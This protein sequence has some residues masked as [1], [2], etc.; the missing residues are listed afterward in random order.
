MRP[1]ISP[2]RSAEHETH[3]LGDPTK[4]MMVRFHFYPQADGSQHPCQP[5]LCREHYREKNWIEGQT[6]GSI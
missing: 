2:I 4:K 3:R 5:D 1:Y 6:H